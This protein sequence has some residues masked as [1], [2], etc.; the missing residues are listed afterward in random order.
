MHNS[1]ETI[2]QISWASDWTE[3]SFLEDIYLIHALYFKWKI[4]W[5]IA[6]GTESRMCLP[7]FSTPI[8]WYL[9]G[10]CFK[11]FFMYY[12][13]PEL[14]RMVFREHKQ[15]VLVLQFCLKSLGTGL[16]LSFSIFLA[17][18]PLSPCSYSPLG[19]CI[20]GVLCWFHFH[21]YSWIKM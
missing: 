7:Y 13:N 6:T 4:K 12:S 3:L 15:E 17:H 10:V 2:F 20:F 21:C 9:P 19:P 16:P 11:I 8:C 18:C 1:F 14:I 5:G